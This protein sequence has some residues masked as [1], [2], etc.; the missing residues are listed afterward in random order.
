MVT[1]AFTCATWNGCALSALRSATGELAGFAA[2]L[3]LC[4]QGLQHRLDELK[5]ALAGRAS[6][7]PP[8]LAPD[9]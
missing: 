5:T 9:P 7:R 6:E 4:D 1:Y 3:V 8:G 2:V